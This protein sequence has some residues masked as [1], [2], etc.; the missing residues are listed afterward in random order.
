MFGSCIG[1]TQK[2]FIVEEVRVSWARHQAEQEGIRSVGRRTT[3][4]ENQRRQIA[5]GLLVAWYELQHGKRK[6]RPFERADIP[7]D[8]R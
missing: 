6:Q 8:K 7:T 2:R 5:I 3:D 1:Q 4:A